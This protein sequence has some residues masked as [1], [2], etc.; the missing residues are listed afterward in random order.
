MILDL[1]TLKPRTKYFVL[2]KVGNQRRNR[3]SCIT[4][5]EKVNNQYVFDARPEFGNFSLQASEFIDAAIV[6]SPG[7]TGHFVNRVSALHNLNHVRQIVP[8]REPAEQ[9]YLVCRQCGEAF[10]DIK[11]AFNHK[12]GDCGSVL[13]FD[14]LP[15]SEAM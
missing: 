11:I 1:G 12:P 10:D 8:E 14:I 4:F 2:H 7:D 5:L 3:L 13:G 15:E 9:L 6:P